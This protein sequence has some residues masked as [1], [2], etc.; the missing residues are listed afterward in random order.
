MK[1]RLE[2]TIVLIVIVTIT[3]GLLGVNIFEKI[4]CEEYGGQWTRI[5]DGGCSMDL[6]E[7]R[8]S[9]GIPIDCLE[10]HA[11]F[12]GPLKCTQGCHFR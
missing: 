6:Q 5:I 3:V 7:C 2:L 9:G 11:M 4:Q 10:N 8:E 1:V 12:S